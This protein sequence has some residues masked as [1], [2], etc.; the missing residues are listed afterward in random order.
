MVIDNPSTETTVVDVD[1]SASNNLAL[2]RSQARGVAVGDMAQVI[3]AAQSGPKNPE[4]VANVTIE[5]RA[6]IEVVLDAVD[7][8]QRVHLAYKV[9]EAA[10]TVQ[11]KLE[12]G[13][14]LW[15][16][17]F[18]QSGGYGIALENP[19]EQD[20]TLTFDFG[21]AANLF[22]KTPVPDGSTLEAG[23]KVA[24]RMRPKTGP[25]ELCTLLRREAG[26]PV[27]LAYGVSQRVHA[28]HGVHGSS[29]PPPVPHARPATAPVFRPDDDV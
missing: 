24:R 29:R 8:A 19:T 14:V 12:S 16:C 7:A 26:V 3:G 20:V 4:M 15:I 21:K 10:R 13:I 18:P 27:K 23:V 22:V 9:S 6:V 17:A 1:F 28:A 5:P 25:A 2:R 11:R